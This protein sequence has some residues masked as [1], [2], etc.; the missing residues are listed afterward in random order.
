MAGWEQF[1]FDFQCFIKAMP[2]RMQRSFRKK[3]T[4]IEHDI[5]EGRILILQG[6]KP[7]LITC[8]KDFDCLESIIA[9]W[10]SQNKI[11]DNWKFHLQIWYNNI[12]LQ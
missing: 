4:Q 11:Y 10:P 1:H 6:T 9:A 5:F 12:E 7:K 8:F 3:P 2:F